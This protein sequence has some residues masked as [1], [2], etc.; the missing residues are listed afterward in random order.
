MDRYG[1]HVPNPQ[2][3]VRLAGGLAVDPYRALRNK[4]G[5][6]GAGAKD[7]GAPEPFVEPLP[8]PV[9]DVSY[10]T[11]P[12]RRTARAANGPWAGFADRGTSGT[13]GRRRRNGISMGGAG[14]PC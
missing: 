10:R 11:P 9:L 6:I 12:L 5:A 1:Q 4:V 8:I 14:G 2:L 3:G 7:A 13:S